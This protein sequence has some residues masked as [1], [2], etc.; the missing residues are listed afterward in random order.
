MGTH[1][2][3]SPSSAPALMQCACYKSHSGGDDPFS[4]ANKGTA[5]H[6]Y[7]ES[8]IIG[9]TPED[10]GVL[11]DGEKEKCETAAANVIAFCKSHNMGCKIQ[12]EIPVNILDVRGKVISAGT[13]DI[14]SLPDVGGDLKSGFDFKPK[15]HD[16]KPQQAFYALGRMQELGVD[17]LHWFEYYILPEKMITYDLTYDECIAIVRCVYLRKYSKDKKP[18]ACHFCKNCDNILD[19]PAVNARIKM[20]SELYTDLPL[21]DHISAPD[22]I[23]D[24]EE[25]AVLLTAAK[26]QLKQ[27]TKRIDEVVD[28]VEDAALKLY[29]SGVRIPYY[30]LVGKSK[31]F[32]DD[33]DRAFGLVPDLPVDKFKQAI[34]ISIPK[35]AEIYYDHKKSTGEKMTKKDARNEL[36]ARLSRVIKNGEKTYSLERKMER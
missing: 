2:E 10:T 35:L 26:D 12:V 3:L 21:S 17:R 14:L 23:I 1:H 4:D 19:C 11:D 15:N 16:Y 5:L 32:I 13:Q 34:S 33:L 20:V 8:L 18:Q 28:S 29:D 6:N 27:Y 22:K 36:E 24:G 25:M 31:S 9:E 30:N 7:T